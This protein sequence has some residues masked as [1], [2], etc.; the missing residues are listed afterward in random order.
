VKL[1]RMIVLAL[2]GSLLA[3]VVI[4]TLI[5]RQ[6]EPSERYI[7]RAPASSAVPAGPLHVAHPGA[8]VLLSREHEEEIGE[9][10]QVANARVG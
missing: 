2:L 7:G 3:G 4:G 8:L 5:R 10:V 6:I 1:I 9:P